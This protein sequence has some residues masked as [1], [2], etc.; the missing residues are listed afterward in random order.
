MPSTIMRTFVVLCVL[1]TF[2]SAVFAARME[3]AIKARGHN[4]KLLKKKDP[5]AAQPKP[6]ALYKRAEATSSTAAV[7]ASPNPTSP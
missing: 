5:N 4:P 1:C 7:A 6:N 2:I 3:D